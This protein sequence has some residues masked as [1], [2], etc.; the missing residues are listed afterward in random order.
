MLHCIVKLASEMFHGVKQE[1]VA[2]TSVAK[3]MGGCSACS[4]FRR[5]R[6]NARMRAHSMTEQT[7]LSARPRE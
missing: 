2:E 7:D 1:D 5:A 6:L 3:P 4:K